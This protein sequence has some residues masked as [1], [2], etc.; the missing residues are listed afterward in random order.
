MIDQ[1]SKIRHDLAKKFV[2]L[3]PYNQT[4]GMRLHATD[5]QWCALELPYRQDLVGNPET[6]V[7]HGGVITALQD[8]AFGL[9]I[10]SQQA[11]FRPIATLDLRI[12]YLK[13]ATPGKSVYAGAVCYKT[14]SQF[15]FVRGATYHD[16]P[17]DPIATSVGIFMFTGVAVA[18]ATRG[19]R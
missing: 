11:K 19:K 15:A 12:D 3:I 5:A 4:L 18:E 6:G 1:Q 10:L 14:T 7:L 2:E 13:P 17:D 9:A 8:V 16:T